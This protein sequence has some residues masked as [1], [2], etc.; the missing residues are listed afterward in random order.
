VDD[1]H[2]VSDVLALAGGVTGQG[3]PDEVELFRGSQRLE[4]S[5]TR[6]TQ[7]AQLPLQSGDQLF[8]PE[9]SWFER[10][11]GLLAAFVS[12]AFGLAVALILKP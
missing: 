3:E 2:S 6:R 8:V 1:T 4:G 9:R 10:N 5:I 11:T 7:I 12:G